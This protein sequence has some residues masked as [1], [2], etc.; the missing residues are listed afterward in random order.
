MNYLFN[1][2]ANSFARAM[3]SSIAFLIALLIIG[4]WF[5]SGK[6][7]DYS[8]SWQLFINS[9]TTI[10]TF[11]MVFIIQTTQNRD[12]KTIHLK[13]DELIKAQKGAR[14]GLIN[15]EKYS[16][17]ELIML[18]KEFHKLHMRGRKKVSKALHDQILREHIEEKDKSSKSSKNNFK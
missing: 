15:M 5:V 7:F 11:L 10:I 12:T 3:G 2:F 13:L 9:F 8:E 14:V 18:E 6:Y 16:D 1:K 17:E 4:L